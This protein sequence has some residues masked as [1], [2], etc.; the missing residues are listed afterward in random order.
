MPFFKSSLTTGIIPNMQEKTVTA[1]TSNISVSADNGYDGMSRVTVQ[2][3]PT[4]SKTQAAALTNQTVIVIPDSGYHLDSVEVTPGSHTGTYYPVENTAQNDMGEFHNKRYVNTNGM[5][6]PAGTKS[7][8]ANGTDI[9]VSEYEFVDVNVSGGGEP[10]EDRFL[11][12]RFS[13]E[14]NGNNSNV[15]YTVQTEGWYLVMYSAFLTGL[16]QP[17]YASPKLKVNDTSK[18]ATLSATSY[19]KGSDN[20]FTTSSAYLH[21]IYCSVGDVITSASTASRGYY[22]RI[23]KYT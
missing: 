8:T 17:T 6:R 16:S 12:S 19:V 2:P 13:I 9:D 14:T 22:I 18:T 21:C 10:I 15:N 3:T 7:I 4:Q 5:I 11:S 23:Y 1:G 20:L